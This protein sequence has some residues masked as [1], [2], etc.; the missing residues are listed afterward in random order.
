MV[1]GIWLAELKDLSFTVSLLQLIVNEGLSCQR[2]VTDIIAILKKCAIT[3]PNP[4]CPSKVEVTTPHAAK[5]V[6]AKACS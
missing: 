1:K 6:G 5:S 4:G 3:Q 2:A